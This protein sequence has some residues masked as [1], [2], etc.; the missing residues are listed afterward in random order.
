MRV[1]TGTVRNGKIEVDGLDLPEGEEVSVG[2][3]EEEPFHLTPEQE[4]ELQASIDEADRGE[5]EDMADVLAR[6]RGV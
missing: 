4:A 6:L 2:L 5:T 1:V 3:P